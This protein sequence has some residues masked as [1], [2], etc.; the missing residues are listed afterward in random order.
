M[1]RKAS[2][3]TALIE[4]LLIFILA[5]TVFN[6][7][8]GIPL[9][10]PFPG[11]GF[12]VSYFAVLVMI[13]AY[14]ALRERSRPI[15]R[16]PTGGRQAELRLLAIAALPTL[17]IKAALFW[18]DWGQ[19]IGAAAISIIIVSGILIIARVS[20][21]PDPGPTTLLALGLILYTSPP[22]Q[23]CISASTWPL[24][25]YR[26]FYI[27]LV[28]LTEE[29]L[30]RGMIFTKLENASSMQWELLKIE[31][32]PALLASSVL[33]GLWHLINGLLLGFGALQSS[34]W[35]LWTFFLGIFLG[36]LRMRSNRIIAPALMHW[37]INI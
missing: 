26:I 36:L 28:A 17:L 4:S 7:T 32:T 20:D 5:I 6:L 25:L 14:F 31:F 1:K 19:W 16:R 27:G 11:A 34:G 10:L 35:A 9:G 23:P 24:F 37:V 15:W 12:P 18:L 3:K 13:L 8:R 30:F 2:Q 21:H 33:F 22:I 29:S